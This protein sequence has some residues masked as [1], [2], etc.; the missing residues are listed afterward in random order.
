MAGH[1]RSRTRSRD[2]GLTRGEAHYRRT[3]NTLNAKLRE[4]PS[5]EERFALCVEY[6]RAALAAARRRGYSVNEGP[7]RIVVETL[8]RSIIAAADRLLRPGHPRK[9]GE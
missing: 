7:G 1:R 5:Q 4:T 6:F 3:K 9:E 8:N 2:A